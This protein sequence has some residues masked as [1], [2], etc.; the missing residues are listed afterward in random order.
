MCEPPQYLWVDT[1]ECKSK[2]QTCDELVGADVAGGN[3]VALV[4]SNWYHPQTQGSYQYQIPTFQQWTQAGGVSN[5]FTESELSK[6]SACLT[7]IRKTCVDQNLPGTDWTGGFYSA[8]YHEDLDYCMLQQLIAANGN[9]AVT[10]NTGVATKDWGYTMD[11]SATPVLVDLMKY[12]GSSYL[13]SNCTPTEQW[14]IDLITKLKCPIRTYNFNVVTTPISLLWGD[15]VDIMKIATRTKFPLNPELSG[16]WFEWRASGY[17]PLVVWDPDSTGKITEA[18]QLFGTSTWG[19]KWSNGYEALATL[20]ANHNGWLEGTELKSIALWFDFNQ[21]GISDK[22]EVKGLAS[23]GVGVE[24]IGV[25]GLST[26]DVYGNIFVEQ[27]YKRKKGNA[28]VVGRSVDW[29]AGYKDAR[30]GSE[31]LSKDLVVPLPKDVLA[32]K[33]QSPATNDLTGF[34]DWQVVAKDE[35]PQNLPAG[36]LRIRQRDNRIEG[37][38]MSSQSIAPNGMG[39][40]SRITTRPFA[41][42]THVDSAGTLSFRFET[43]DKGSSPVYTLAGMTSDGSTLKGLTKEKLPN[44]KWVEYTWIARRKNG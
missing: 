1:C 3:G 44:G 30:L 24:A 13:N 39:V 29:F 23:E 35:F 22:D 33:A 17:S 36:M 9:K 27:G 7:K 34:W 14:K 41:G 26:P 11:K 40:G 16:K 15:R 43:V 20:D 4:N 12:S 37:Y 32:E 38:T 8:R 28:V 6:N 10:S 31:A 18:S 19:K 21:D 2:D 5:I 25:K 42:D